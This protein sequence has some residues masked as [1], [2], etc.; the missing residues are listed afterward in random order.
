MLLRASSV[1]V[2]FLL[3]FPL[4]VCLESV[5]LNFLSLFHAVNKTFVISAHLVFL[6]GVG[7]YA[8]SERHHAAVWCGRSLNRLKLCFISRP[9]AYVLLLPLMLIIGLSAFLCAPNTYDSMTYHMARIV[10]WIQQGSVGYYITNNHRQNEMGPGAEYL[11][12]FFQIISGSDKLANGIQLLSYILISFGLYY[13]LRLLRVQRHIIPWIILF[14]M[15][16][17]MA[18]L[19]ASSTQ[20][21]LV[22]AQITLCILIT[23]SR[24]ILGDITRMKNGE[25]ALV[26]LCIAAGFLVK[27][28]SIIVALPFIIL[29]IV[30]NFLRLGKVFFVPRRLG[31]LIIATG[32]L[33]LA[34]GP[35][36]FRKISGDVFSRPEVYHLLSGW[37]RTRLFNPIAIIAPN[38]PFP[39]LFEKVVRTIGL[40][41]ELHNRNI[42]HINEDFIGNPLQLFAL[43]FLPFFTLGLYPICFKLKG[44][45]NNKKALS[46]M[47][48]PVVSWCFFGWVVKNQAW[49]TRL[50]LP[51]FFLVPFSLAILFS[52]KVGFHNKK[53]LY[54]ISL[55]FV[56]FS[57]IYSVIV[58]SNNP[59]KPLEA[60]FFWGELPS[61][62][63]SYYR[64]TD[65]KKTHDNFL[66]IA[67][68]QNC[69]RADMLIT[70]DYPEYPLTW[71]AMQ[72]NIEMRH[73]FPPQLDDWPC[74]LFADGV[75]HRYVP[76]RGTRWLNLGDEHTFVRN[77]AYDFENT[78]S[79]IFLLNHWKKALSIIPGNQNTI[80]EYQNT[81]LL[82]IA[83]DNDPHI[84][85]PEVKLAEQR[86][87]II[88]IVLDSPVKTHLKIYYRIKKSENYSEEQVYNY[89][90]EKGN[91][92]VY[93]Q[94][95]GSEI[96]G[97][98]RFDPGE[99]AGSYMLYSIE[100]RAI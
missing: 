5:I 74:M 35:D 10:Q 41:I 18:V 88:K 23:V 62:L 21:D 68:E 55:L 20:N 95:Y 57:Y 36:I 2:A 69:R 45:K 13:L 22:D 59:S 100:I 4:F 86:S 58:V 1:L 42:F 63:E 82:I 9:P 50:E 87:S 51:L 16:T 44:L 15:T 75:K 38:F 65:K 84:I 29:G 94:L 7:L 91:N 67:H 56:L 77:F 72:Q 14:C 83:Q 46:L 48:L 92:V 39:E 78:S 85:I 54:P 90:I 93:F 12:L 64:N 28:I 25:M 52:S 6:V 40:P 43:I 53:G 11:I 81:H 49:I 61:A 76:D 71:R 24:L 99:D 37:D 66:R 31:G 26:S 97:D 79:V 47:F 89:P 8:F 73:S 19:Q 3:A 98:L 80:L 33:S 96:T 30:K 17:P 27:P 32:L 34:C 60:R 70:P